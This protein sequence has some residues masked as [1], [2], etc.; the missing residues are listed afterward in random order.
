MATAG[1]HRVFI[2]GYYGFGN[3][4]DEAILSAMLAD[5]QDLGRALKICVAS[6]QP[7]ETAAWHGVEAVHW[8]DLSA[9]LQAVDRSDLILV[10]GGGLFNSYL[11]HDSRLVLTQRHS[12]FSVFILGIPVLA[13]LAGKPCV[14][15]AVGADRFLSDEAKR[16]AYWAVELSSLCTVRDEGSREILAEIG[17]RAERIRVTA[18][19]AFRLRDLDRKAAQ[20]LWEKENLPLT[21]PKLAVVV[22]NWPFSGDPAVTERAVGEGLR[23]FVDAQGA[24]LVFMPFHTSRAL[25]ELSN[26]RSIIARLVR[27]IGRP[28]RTV[29]LDRGY[30][31]AELSALIACCDLALSMRLHGVILATKNRVP[32]VAVAYAPK[33][34]NMMREAR[35]ED[36]VLKPGGLSGER[37]FAAL[38]AM[39]FS[40]DKIRTRLTA[41][42]SE[43]A[44]RALET[45]RMVLALLVAPPL[46]SDSYPPGWTDALKS[47]ALRQTRHILELET[48]NSGYRKAL[49][50]LV[51]SRRYRP[52]LEICEALLS[53]AP[54]HPEGNYLKAFCLHNLGGDGE[55]ALRHYTA[56]L[57]AGFSPFWV[58]YNRGSLHARLGRRA[59]AVADLKK[60]RKLD[61]KHRGVTKVLASLGAIPRQARRGRAPDGSVLSNSTS[62]RC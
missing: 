52:A 19:P 40:R 36:W 2:A 42:A 15:Y 13:A 21:S 35:M 25:G 28:G 58:L 46:P 29:V 39:L 27:A 9:V 17:C 1:S 50:N 53:E 23:K 12:L 22:R 30:G 55:M 60:A 8:R 62:E 24:S 47:L 41:I 11:E 31:P 6:D 54:N 33:V 59:E 4:G 20:T 18:D 57:E 61:P 48:E 32:C 26:D 51:D 34:S 14:I 16:D 5:L 45:A 44:D 38:E 10:G 49:R 43:M 37:V 3:I 7:A 56:A